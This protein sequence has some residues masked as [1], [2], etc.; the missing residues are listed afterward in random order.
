MALNKT[1][2]IVGVGWFVLINLMFYGA[3]LMKLLNVNLERL[4][5][6]LFKG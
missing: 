5:Q 2:Q 4:L 1:K 6:L 3:I